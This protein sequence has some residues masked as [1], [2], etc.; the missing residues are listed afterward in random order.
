MGEQDAQLRRELRAAAAVNRQLHAQLDGSGAAGTRSSGIGDD[1][2]AVARRGDMG[3]AWLM[4][5]ADLRA[6][7]AQLA[8]VDG[9]TIVVEGGQRREVSSRLLASALASRLGSPRRM[10]AAAASG[11]REGPPVEIV[12][13]PSGAPFV[14]VG[15]QR[16]PVRG[17]PMTH[18]VG[19]AELDLFPIG[20]P[21]DLVASHVPRAQYKRAFTGRA[22]L[23]WLR[24]QVAANGG[25][26]RG[27]VAIATKAARRARASL[28][29]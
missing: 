16:L 25:P 8:E 11:L 21:I 15:G 4:L 17:L 9:R 14:I 12:E 19:N 3:R 5:L 6:G 20:K 26:V 22:Q 2:G 10:A 1:R 29:R 13:G 24:E 27:T 23:D 18:P 7:K 28:S